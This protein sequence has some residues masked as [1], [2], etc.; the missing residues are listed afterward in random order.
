[1]NQWA[2]FGTPWGVRDVNGITMISDSPAGFYAN[3]IDKSVVSKD[4]DVGTSDLVLEVRQRFD[5]E[6]EFDFGFIELSLDGGLT[7]KEAGRVNGTS[8]WAN[9]SYSLKSVLGL[10]QEIQTS[11]SREVRFFGSYEGWDVDSLRMIGVKP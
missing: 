1:M 3:G 8:D 11:S 10:C 2:A 6:K 5:L 9:Q 4:I 7:W